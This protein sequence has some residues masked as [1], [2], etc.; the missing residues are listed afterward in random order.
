MNKTSRAGVR[1]GAEKA[2]ARTVQASLSRDA[3]SACREAHWQRQ[4]KCP[5]CDHRRELGAPVDG[6]SK[7]ERL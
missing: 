4:L 7:K 6:V 2:A 1:Q 3:W 5:A